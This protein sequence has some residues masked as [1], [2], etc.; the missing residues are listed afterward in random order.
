M[1]VAEVLENA[2]ASRDERSKLNVKQVEHMSEITAI[3]VRA[4]FEAGAAGNVRCKLAAL[5][6]ETIWKSTN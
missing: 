2:V 1:N 5:Q 6:I 3:A 4:V